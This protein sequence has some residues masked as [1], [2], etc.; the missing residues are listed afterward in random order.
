[1]GSFV[2]NFE[3]SFTV[4]VL[5]HSLSMALIVVHSIPN[6][7]VVNFYMIYF[8]Q[9]CKPKTIH[10]ELTHVSEYR[11]FERYTDIPSFIDQIKTTRT[12]SSQALRPQ[13]H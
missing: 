5:T 12:T 9:L 6:V 10:N 4:Y 3:L 1:M 7:C 2:L 8:V 13:E 11:A